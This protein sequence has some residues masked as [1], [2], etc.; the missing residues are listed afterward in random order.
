[1]KKVMK[2]LALAL[3]LCMVLSVSAFAVSETGKTV[4]T[5]AHTVTFD[6]TGLQKDE[7]VALL[8]LVPDT[9]VSAADDETILYIDQTVANASGVA[10]FAATIAEGNDVVDVWVG[11][12]T[13]NADKTGAWNVYSNVE[14]ANVSN[15]TFTAGNVKYLNVGDQDGAITRPGA[16]IG[17]NINNVN[18]TKMIWALNAADTANRKFSKSI[19][20]DGTGLSGEVWFTAA[21]SSSTLKD[22][23][24][25]TVGAMF[26]GATDS[27]VYYAGDMSAEIAAASKT[28]NN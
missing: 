23:T 26:R 8:V 11:S 15:I 6:V 20:I 28:P 17:I 19:E 3:A 14:V 9:E 7:Q 12:Q 13:I 24:I 1:M 5:E 27:E 2:A 10:S 22:Y 4:D 16:A 21:F 18:I 25:S